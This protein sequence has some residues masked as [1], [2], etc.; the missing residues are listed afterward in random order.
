MS[1]PSDI[2]GESIWMSCWLNQLINS[3]RIIMCRLTQR[4]LN[5]STQLIVSLVLSRQ[6]Y[7]NAT[8]SGLP[9]YQFRRLQSVINAA[10]R[11]IYNLRWS[12]HVTPALIELHWLSAVDRVNFKVATLVQSMWAERVEN[13]VIGN[14]AVSGGLR[15][16]W[17]M[18]G[19]GNWA[20]SGLNWALKHRSE[21]DPTVALSP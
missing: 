5:R 2:I 15:K 4:G 20:E 19:N 6:D 12:D 16:W 3:N 14:G 9:E 17:S 7:G 13:R 11:S 8:L 10:A 18:S 21:V 1:R